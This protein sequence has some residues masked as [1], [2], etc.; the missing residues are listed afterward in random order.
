MV[1]KPYPYIHIDFVGLIMPIGFGGERYFFTFTHNYTRITKTYTAKQKSECFKCLKVFYNLAQTWTKQDQPTERLQSNY[2]SE[3]LGEKVDKWLTN[4]GIVFK[5]LALYSQEE[6]RVSERT[7]RTIMEMVRA[8]I[9]KRG[10]E[11]IL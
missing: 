4:Q 9:L 8:M 3:L 7:N 6:N 11:D 2:S 10:M 5:P 1:T